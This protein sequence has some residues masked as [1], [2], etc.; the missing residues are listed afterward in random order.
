MNINI[1]ETREIS[2]ESP[3]DHAGNRLNAADVTPARVAL[4]LVLPFKTRPEK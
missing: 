1:P 4:P 3:I 2:P